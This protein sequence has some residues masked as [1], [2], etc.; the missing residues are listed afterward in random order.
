MEK[1]YIVY[2]KGTF[3]SGHKVEGIVWTMEQAKEFAGEL[4]ERIDPMFGIDIQEW[5]MDALRQ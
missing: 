1:V 4:A 3:G 2:R 5:E